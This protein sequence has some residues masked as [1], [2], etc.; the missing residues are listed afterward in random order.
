MLSRTFNFTTGEILNINKP[1]GWS[2]FDVVKKI[3]SRIKVKK[4]GHAGTLDP[5]AT[6]VLLI[7]TGRATKQ[8][9][10]LIK[11]DKEYWAQIELGKTT[12]TYDKTGVVLKESN[13]S[14]IDANAIQNALENFRGEINQTPPMYSA[15][16]V[17]GRRLYQMARRG[18]VIERPPR[19]V[20]IYA[21]ELL[22]FDHPFLAI[23]VCCS[24]GTYI[25]SLAYDLGEALGCGAYLYALKRTRVGPYKIDEALTIHDFI[26]QVSG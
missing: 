17:G 10:E 2:S 13:V 20:N 18:E 6:G 8:V 12:D 24:K 4:V 22:S 16:K 1:E 21:L 19:K 11:L 14:G 26:Q 25:R 7:C 5:F 23:S 15:I 9:S 3:R